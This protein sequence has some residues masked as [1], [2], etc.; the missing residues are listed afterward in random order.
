MKKNIASESDSPQPV[1]FDNK[2]T[3]TKSTEL[4]PAAWAALERL[5]SPDPNIRGNALDHLLA[6]DAHRLS[7]V[8]AYTLAT[9]LEDQDVEFRARI[10]HA[11]G[12]L[13]TESQS[14]RQ[15][16]DSVRQGLK[17]YLSQMRRRKIFALLQVAALRADTESSIAALLNACSFAGASLSQIF[18]D[19]KLPLEIRRQA[20][21]FSGRVGFLDTIP[22]LERLA[23][24]LEARPNGQRAMSFAPPEMEDEKTLLS[25]VQTA[26]RFL[27][28]P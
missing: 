25:A 19:R 7:P 11:L 24:R 26:L 18:L 9:R 5:I 22:A 17:A 1:L 8:I 10:A 6:L 15:T 12:Q 13:L 20:I 28:A 4:F 2:D 14:G 3:L 23:S 21:I 16:P 27:Q